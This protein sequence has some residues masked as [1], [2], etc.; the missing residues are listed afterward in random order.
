MRILA[1]SGNLDFSGSSLAL[2]RFLKGLVSG[3]MAGR[4]QVE[5]L[6]CQFGPPSLKDA[7]TALGIPVIL[8]A[9]PKA[10]DV[11]LCNSILTGA[12][13]RRCADQRPTVW[14]VHEPRFGADMIRK[15]PAL[16]EAFT[17]ATAI[18]FPT[19][20][21]AA[22]V[23]REWLARDNWT[24]VENGVEVDLRPQPRPA[25]L[26]PD[27][28]TILQLGAAEL[29]KGADLTLEAVRRL[30]DP[31]IHLVYVGPRHP[32]FMPELTAM[33]AERV[34][35]AGSRSEA[36]VAAYLQHCDALSCPTRDDLVNLAI[37]EAL[38]SGLP[39][40]ASDVGAIPETIRHD[41]NGLL[42]PVGDAM[43]LTANLARLRDDPALRRRLAVNGL[44]THRDRHTAE[45]HRDGLLAVLEQAAGTAR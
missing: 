24:V 38:Q 23:Y 16:P 43:G 42:S 44:E 30:D 12:L 34:H 13:V 45:R 3:E 7:Y 28:F 33:D 4:H 36:K 9:V 10:Y 2:H 26:P 22:D 14:W 6:W 37:L 8:D 5:L 31:R 20:W 35:F 40:A 11:V 17:A 1:I 29:R 25:D 32:N 15:N 18:V 27:R 21:Q 19:R 39:V 41:W